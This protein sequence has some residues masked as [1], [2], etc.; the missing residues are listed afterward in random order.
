MVTPPT[1]AKLAL[2]T[3]NCIVARSMRSQTQSLFLFYESLAMRDYR[4]D[5]VAKLDWHA[6]AECKTFQ[7]RTTKNQ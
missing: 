4:E 2:C 7:Q 1:F 6:S 5:I 3:L